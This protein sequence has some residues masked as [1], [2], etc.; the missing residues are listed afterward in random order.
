MTKCKRE[1]CNEKARK[2]NPFCSSTCHKTHFA[3]MKCL[4]ESKIKWGFN[5]FVYTNDKQK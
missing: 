2:D 3:E 4:T 1:S 5:L